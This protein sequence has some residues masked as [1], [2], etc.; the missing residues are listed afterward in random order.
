MAADN[1]DA[2]VEHVFS[3]EKGFQNNPKDKG[4]WTG[5][6]VGAGNLVGTKFGISAA[7][8]PNLDIPN[9]TKEQAKEIYREKYWNVIHGDDLPPGVDAEV[10]DMAVHH[11]PGNAAKI[12]QRTVGSKVDGFIGPNTV[13][14]ASKHGAKKLVDSIAKQ[15]MDF[16]MGLENRSDWGGW[17]PRVDSVREFSQS[18]LSQPKIE[19][20][21]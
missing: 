18:L 13:K 8:F 20:P 2:A 9:I 5:G 17:V 19:Q 11:G 6:R 14:A 3:E 4:N 7:A 16:V 15:R 1:F 12:L 10:F 21:R